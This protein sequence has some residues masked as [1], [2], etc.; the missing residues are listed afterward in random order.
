MLLDADKELH[1]LFVLGEKSY[2]GRIIFYPN[3]PVKVV[4]TTTANDHNL[5]INYKGK[6]IDQIFGVLKEEG[7]EITIIDGY[8]I[9]SF[10]STNGISEYTILSNLVIFGENINKTELKISNLHM[11]IPTLN[12]YIG[13]KLEKATFYTNEKI[14][15]FSIKYENISSEFDTPDSELKVAI[16]SF[17]NI[18]KYD[19]RHK[20]EVE[21]FHSIALEFKKNK[22]LYESTKYVFTI[23][24]FFS[25]V[26]QKECFVNEIVYFKEKIFK[27]FNHIYIKHDI[28]NKNDKINYNKVLFEIEYLINN[29]S[30]LISN[31]IKI[32]DEIKYLR[33]FMLNYF[34][35]K[36]IDQK[37]VAQ[38]NLIEALHLYYFGT[39]K[40]DNEIEIVINRIIP[41]ICNE[42]DKDMVKK[43]I[44][45]KNSY[46]INRKI[47][48][49]SAKSNTINLSKKEIKNIVKIRSILSHGGVDEN[50]DFEKYCELSRK[51]NEIIVNIVKEEIDK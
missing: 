40:D 22:E 47:D 28:N 21:Q 3:T 49:I 29:L 33:Y 50:F 23:E 24:A 19:L 38:V 27:P 8:I 44:N 32:T 43:L 51:L 45:S 30:K 34:N 46:G 42:D 20:F 35:N 1:G 7:D 2:S 5:E 12:K 4:I 18:D 9:D 26:F 10:Y 48:E 14:V 17:Y 25:F 6:Y 39:K 16:K 11:M 36:Y 37:I 13:N 31:W 15:D 41:Q